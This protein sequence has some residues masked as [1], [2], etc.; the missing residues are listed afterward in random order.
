[1][2]PCL[3]LL[4]PPLGMVT[5]ADLKEMRKALCEMD[6]HVVSNE[7]GH[8]DVGLTSVVQHILHVKLAKVSHCFIILDL[9]AMSHEAIFFATCN[10]MALHCKLQG[11]LPRVTAHVC[12]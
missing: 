9:K 7:L 4:S 12:N 3:S 11:R 10:A 2:N 1:M 6:K 5:F 8:P